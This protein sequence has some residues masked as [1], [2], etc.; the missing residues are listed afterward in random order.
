MFSRATATS[1]AIP[2]GADLAVRTSTCTVATSIRGPAA[3]G[4]GIASGP[5]ANTPA[6]PTRPSRRSPAPPPLSTDD[7]SSPF[8]S[9]TT[10]VT[11]HTPVRLARR[12]VA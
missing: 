1:S 10:N 12:S 11:P 6:N 5:T 7:R 9:T 8:T 4:N 2:L 3:I